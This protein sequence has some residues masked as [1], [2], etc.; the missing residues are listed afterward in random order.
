MAWSANR[1]F[2][3]VLGIVFVLIGI[4]GLLTANSST[5]NLLGIFGVDLLHNLVHLI[6][7]I[8]AIVAA[9]MG[10][11]RRF[12]QVFGVIYLLLGLAGLIPA[13][14]SGAAGMQFLGIIH[15]NPADNVLHLVAG[16][17]AIIVGF[18]VTETARTRTAL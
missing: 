7:G 8:I 4:L 10:F 1:L 17:A 16:A 6:T 2:A 3:L 12:N 15:I 5:S 11:S 18:F 14:Y 9:Y 13:L